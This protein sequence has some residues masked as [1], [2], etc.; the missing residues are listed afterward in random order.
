VR[1]STG[2]CDEPV[3][4]AQPAVNRGD[5]AAAM[6]ASAKQL[7]STYYWHFHSHASLGP[8]C[9]VADFKESGT[10]IWSSTQDAYGLRSIL[11]VVEYSAG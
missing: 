5:T 4:T 2:T 7:A 11:T 1:V 8:S 6:A 10:T 9:V 3:E